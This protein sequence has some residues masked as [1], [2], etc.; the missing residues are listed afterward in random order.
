MGDL[1]VRD[2]N[3]NNIAVQDIRNQVGAIQKLMK[4]VMQDGTHYGKIP[5]TG[6]PSLWKA[7]A[8]K[9]IMLFQLAPDYDEI[10]VVEEKDFVNYRIKCNLISP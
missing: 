9:I 3:L 2:D 7:G 8:E 6:K 10:A 1:V 4:E 5:G